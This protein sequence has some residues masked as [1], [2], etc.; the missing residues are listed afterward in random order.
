MSTE[1]FIG[2]IK[3][4]GFSWSPMG[5]QPCNGQLIPI[6]Q[7]TALF[8]L[9]GTFYGGNGQTT[10]ALPNL[11]GVKAMKLEIMAK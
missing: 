7:Y 9:I 2:E 5:Y 6:A 10:F 3:I 8:S 4:L 1:P 11:Q